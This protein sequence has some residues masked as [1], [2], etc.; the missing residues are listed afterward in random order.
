MI[1]VFFPNNLLNSYNNLYYIF[2][3]ENRFI[4]F[5]VFKLSFLINSDLIAQ[6]TLPQNHSTIWIFNTSTPNFVTLIY[7]YYVSW[8]RSIHPCRRYSLWEFD[9][10]NNRLS[11]GNM[12]FKN[13]VVAT[14]PFS[15]FSTAID[16]VW[17]G[18]G[19]RETD[20]DCKSM[21]RWVVLAVS[22]SNWSYIDEWGTFQEHGIRWDNGLG[23][24]LIECQSIA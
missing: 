17:N 8:R 10:A 14:F 24:D 2:R 12:H 19:Q 15:K 23:D 22:R 13:S 6:L 9:S 11:I 1:T 20:L 18:G 3:N 5:H 16:L 21:H 7:P 4:Y